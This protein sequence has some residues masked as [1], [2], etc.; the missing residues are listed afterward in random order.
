MNRTE[1]RVFLLYNVI[2]SRWKTL[3]DD[4]CRSYFSGLLPTPP[5]PF[6][7]ER[8]SRQF[9]VYPCAGVDVIVIIVIVIVFVHNRCPSLYRVLF[10]QHHV[11][12]TEIDFHLR[13]NDLAW[14]AFTPTLPTHFQVPSSLFFSNFPGLHNT[15]P[16]SL[17]FYPAR[18]SN[19]IPIARC[20]Y[21]R[22]TLA[23]VTGK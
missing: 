11:T 18:I 23:R 5:P 2:G 16:A 4:S 17:I 8:L 10:S 3:W 15:V 12:I 21:T 20:E 14:W 6:S 13:V 1:A 22:T 7:R 9:N 19:V